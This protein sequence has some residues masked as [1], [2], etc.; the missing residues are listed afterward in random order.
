M[1]RPRIPVFPVLVV[2]LTFWSSVRADDEPEGAKP[3]RAD[4]RV[5]QRQYEKAPADL[6]I[7]VERSL[8]MGDAS[9][10]QDAQ[11]KLQK[12]LDEIFALLPERP[13]RRL[14]Q[15]RF[16]LMWGTD[17][18]EGG[19]PSGMSYIRNGEPTRYPYLDPAW[20]DVIVVYSAKNLM[21]L[22]S[23]WTKKALM[24]EL[25]HAWH[26]LNW[27]EKHR[28]IEGAY[29]AAMTRGLYRNVRDNKG[30]LIPNAY[31]ARN[32]LEYFAELS[33]MYFVGGNYFPFDRAGL[34]EYDPI[35][36]SMVRTLWRE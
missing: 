34:T 29:K 22:D 28:P 24:H 20:N 33:A 2:L 31:A 4:F 9:L 13:A 21:Y 35:G 10:S 16:Y 36:E 15:L 1:L 19:R 32:R 5:P 18:P 3:A 23:L 27:P 6:N 7:Y 26:I 17:A 14:K 25:A 12:N 30:K 8:A 11:R